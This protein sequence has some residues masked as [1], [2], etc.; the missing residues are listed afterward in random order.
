MPLYQI[1]FENLFENNETIERETKRKNMEIQLRSVKTGLSTVYDFETAYQMVI[2]D[3]TIWKISFDWNS[4][5]EE[6]LKESQTTHYGHR[7][8]LIRT[9]D[10]TW[11]NY[12]MIFVS[13]PPYYD[14]SE[15]PIPDGLKEDLQ[16]SGFKLR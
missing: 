16:K 11:S 3:R 12:P 10:N 2:K 4:E 8:Q 14:D 7:F 13:E 9:E 5:S 1:I 15:K 6:V